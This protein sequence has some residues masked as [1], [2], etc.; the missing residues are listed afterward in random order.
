VFVFL[1]VVQFLN[2]TREKKS[3]VLYPYFCWPCF[4]F[5]PD[6]PRILLLEFIFHLKNFL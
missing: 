4:A 3:I 1:L 6:G 5:L 2:Q